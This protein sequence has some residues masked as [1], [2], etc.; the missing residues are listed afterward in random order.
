MLVAFATA[1]HIRDDE[2][3]DVQTEAGDDV[4]TEEMWTRTAESSQPAKDAKAIAKDN[5]QVLKEL[6]KK[7]PKVGGIDVADWATDD[8]YFTRV[9]HQFSTPKLSQS[10]SETGE[11]IISKEDTETSMKQI[12]MEKI[13]TGGDKVKAVNT[14]GRLMQKYFKDNWEYSDAANEGAIETSRAHT[15][16][17]KVINNIKLDEDEEGLQWKTQ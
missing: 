3:T 17:H 5:E 11:K 10:G 8:V 7:K 16:I 12:L 2:N 13:D 15:F 6:E 14:V 9:F 4:S 1:I